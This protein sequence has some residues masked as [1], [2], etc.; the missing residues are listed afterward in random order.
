MAY[1]FTKLSDVTLADTIES[2]ANVL[3]EENGEIKKVS[4]SAIGAQADWNETDETSPAYILNK[5]ESLGGYKYYYYYNYYLYK[6]NSATERPGN[7]GTTEKAISRT[8]FENDYYSSP[9]MINCAGTIAPC[10]WYGDY[11]NVQYVSLKAP[12][13]SINNFYGMNVQ[14]GSATE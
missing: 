6:T 1:E 13:A 5:P 8:A 2:S 12:N 7:V 11:S 4:K 9:I 3:I 10:I 14:W